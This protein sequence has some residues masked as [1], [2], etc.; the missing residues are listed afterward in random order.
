MMFFNFK[1][2]N[3]FNYSK[4]FIYSAIPKNIRSLLYVIASA[5]YVI[6]YQKQ[7]SNEY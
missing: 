1:I 7:H 6:T 4:K 5:K 3:P 2:T